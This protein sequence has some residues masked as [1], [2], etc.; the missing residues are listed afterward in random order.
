MK[1]PPSNP[2]THWENLLRQARSDVGPPVSLPALLRAVH[3]APLAAQESWATEFS[4]FFSSGRIIPGCLA[5]ATAFALLATW[6]VWDS[7]QTL[8]WVQLLDAAAGGAS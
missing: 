8:P 1:T 6:Q 7:W 5:G 2:D 4:A 3:Q